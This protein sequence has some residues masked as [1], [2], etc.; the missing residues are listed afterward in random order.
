VPDVRGSA[1]R[2]V[3]IVPALA[4]AVLAQEP[5]QTFRTTTR[6]VEVPVVV[7]DRIGRAVAGLTRDDFELTEDGKPQAIS[8]FDVLD[9]RAVPSRPAAPTE[10]ETDEASP[11][12]TNHV[13]RSG[14]SA[15]VILLDRLNA[16]FDSQW[17]AKIGVDRALQVARPDDRIALYALDGG[18][19]VLHDF[20][21]DAA[22]LR[23]ALEQYQ[24]RVSG[25][26]DASTDPGPNLPPP[27]PGET[28]PV[29]IVDPSL[30]VSEFYQRERWRATFQSLE[31]LAG[32]LDGVEGRKS[33]VWVSEVFPMPTR[34]AV[35]FLELM[36]K[37][38]RALSSAQAALYPVDS[39][40][41]VGAISYSR[42]GE[43][44]LNTFGDVRSNIETMEVMAE[45]TGGRPFAN[46]NALDVSVRR[47]LDD[48]R[49][50]YLLGYHPADSRADG[51][52]R[53]ISVKV[54]RKALT[55]R[56]RAGYVAAET[57]S[58]QKARD[59]AIK[60][61]L[62]GPLTATQVGL[63]AR[64]AYSGESSLNVALTVDAS[65]LTLEQ[66]DGLWRGEVDVLVAE[67]TKAG[68]G[69]IVRTERLE[70]SIPNERRADVLTSGLP[71]ALDGLPLTRY[72]HELRIVARDVASGRVGSLVISAPALRR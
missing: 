10:E 66:R 11:H 3:L 39:R 49:L 45:E 37:A 23:R 40:G 15:V 67:V 63:S 30:A 1:V 12:F 42:T 50:V 61:A 56:A 47:A 57:P 25:A 60:E 28:V 64:T 18:I 65:T 33:V 2:T 69:S 46:S 55:V 26:Y 7:T 13:P 51:R 70:L 32:H 58:D 4:C 54:K 9:T 38:T 43:A 31:A 19:R 14:A 68:R 41:L 16:G 44:R 27:G 6:L 36:R 22:S 34:G 72:L 17:F 20:T 59:A 35:E 48:A 71:L 24:A 29:W 21:T 62:R 5:P 52:F 53:A 8:V